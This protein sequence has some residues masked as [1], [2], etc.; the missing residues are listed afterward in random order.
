MSKQQYEES[1]KDWLLK[2][3]DR[4]I[5]DLEAKLAESEEAIKYLKGIKKYDIGE[6][7]TENT[8]LKQQLAEK[9]KLIEFYINSG[10]EQCEEINKLNN[11]ALNY[12]DAIDKHNQDKISFCVEQ[13]EKVKEYLV[14]RARKIKEYN[15]N[16]VRLYSANKF[17]DNQI[18]RLQEKKDE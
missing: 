12:C 18:K 9:D 13:L 3:K 4:T 17:I 2:D 1:S 7:L 8:R 10:K 6:M 11:R 15:V 16:V 14:L 5:A